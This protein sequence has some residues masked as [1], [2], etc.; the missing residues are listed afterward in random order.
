VQIENGQII[1]I[2]DGPAMEVLD[3]LRIQWTK[4]VRRFEPAAVIS[5]PGINVAPSLQVII[6]SKNDNEAL[7]SETSQGLGLGSAE[8]RN[9]A[10]K[11]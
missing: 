9:S 8:P 1:F 6:R 2:E 3:T 5:A 7:K 4:E 11:A 10:S